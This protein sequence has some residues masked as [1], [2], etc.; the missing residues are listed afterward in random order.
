[1]RYQG[2]RETVMIEILY[3]EGVRWAGW[4]GPAN[5]R[6]EWDRIMGQHLS[7]SFG[8]G[9]YGRYNFR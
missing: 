5:L 3:A 6:R 8:P 7:G 2:I 1:M 9:T 4:Y